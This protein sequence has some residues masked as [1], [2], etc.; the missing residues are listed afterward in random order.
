VKGTKWKI[1]AVEKEHFTVAEFQAVLNQ[2]Q[3]TG[4]DWAW[5]DV[6][7]IDQENE[8]LNAQE[9][10][11][12]ASIFRKAFGVYVWL[13]SI[14]T[15]TLQK[16]VNEIN[17][18][19]P[20]LA[21]C[22]PYLPRDGP[23]YVHLNRLSAAFDIFFSDP[24]F[25]SLWTLQE[26]ILRHDA[27]VLSSSA[28]PVRWDQRHLT[29]LTMIINACRNIY[30]DL[31]IV[32]KA[33][34]IIERDNGFLN[35]DQKRAL[36]QIGRMTKHI[37]R[38]GF[39]FFIGVNPNI[40]YSVAKY[41]RTSRE[42]D[43]IYAIMQIY[44]LRVGKS[45]RPGDKPTLPSLITEF[46]LAITTQS[47]AIGQAFVHTSPPAKGMSWRITEDSTVPEFLSI[48]QNLKP[49]CSAVHDSSR[50]NLRVTGKLCP[51]HLFA[52][53]RSTGNLG[54][55]PIDIN[56]PQESSNSN[57][58]QVAADAMDK[59]I[60]RSTPLG[61]FDRDPYGLFSYDKL[62]EKY[63]Q[64]IWIMYLADADRGGPKPTFTF[65]FGLLV[66]PGVKKSGEWLFG[67]EPPDC[68][69]VGVCSFDPELV[70]LQ[71]ASWRQATIVLE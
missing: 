57:R 47:P 28:E 5:V 49:R 13:S 55:L 16:V 36:D 68:R 39:N 54:G 18:A 31:G 48:Y 30:K 10:G 43:R 25:S 19:G 27:K 35:S 46:A 44:N 53:L 29:F 14:S 56:P 65:T 66:Y 58:F 62:V 50:N 34:R 12:Q 60:M 59:E 61:S 1:P 40:Q 64:N 15:D 8:I 67:K 17:E 20:D 21:S 3:D 45:A 63:G 26:V 23:P 7:C 37:L 11:R 9:V 33:V 38:S 2:M 22:I 24:W 71:S 69:R 32:E 6:A 4:V 51:M 41:R 70:E 52:P 42:E